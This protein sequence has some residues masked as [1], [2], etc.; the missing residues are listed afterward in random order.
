VHPTDRLHALDA[1]RGFALILG[2]FFHGSVGYVENFPPA[3]WPMREPPSATLGILFFVSHMFRMSLFFLL[4]GFFGRMMLERQGAR[5]FL[6]DRAKRILVPLVVGLPL[7]LLSMGVFINLGAMLTGT[8]LASLMQQATGEVPQG[9]TF[10]WLHLWFLFYLLIF[11]AIALLVRGSCSLADRSG[12][13]VAGLDAIVRFCSSGIWGPVLIGLPLAAYFCTLDG[14][15]SWTGLPAPLSL[16]PHPASL[17]GYGTAFSFGWLAHRQPD[18]LL[19]LGQR[20][21]GFLTFA[22]ALTFA[23]LLIGGTTPQFEQNLDGQPLMWYSA[24]YFVSIWAWIFGL[25]GLAVRFLSGASPVRRYLADSSYWLYLMHMPLIGFFAAWL[26]P[27]AWH[28]TLKYPV[29]IAATLAVLLVSYHYLVRSTF[30][31][32]LLNGRRHARTPRQ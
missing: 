26:N 31:G 5:G 6:A 8:D 30:I 10:S 9:A 25:I 22:V 1:I 28:W 13:L 14:W 29:Q 32:V 17:L 11:Y 19:A 21:L 3:L 23:C 27:L 12:R 16:A 18:R 4:A 15:P 7:I 2:I 24:A 20:W